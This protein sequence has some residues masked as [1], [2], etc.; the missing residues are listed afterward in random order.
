[1]DDEYFTV[2]KITDTIPNSPAS[3][4]LSSQAKSNVWIVAINGEQPI[5]SQG[6]IDELNTHQTPRG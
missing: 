3:H 6:V 2:P 5:K 4:Q 1:M